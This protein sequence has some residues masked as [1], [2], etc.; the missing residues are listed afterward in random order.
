MSMKWS[1]PK[2][3]NIATLGDQF[4]SQQ[5]RDD[6]SV[7]LDNGSQT[8]NGKDSQSGKHANQYHPPYGY[9]YPPSQ[10][11]LQGGPQLYH[12]SPFNLTQHIL[13]PT[14]SVSRRFPSYWP[15]WQRYDLNQG[16]WDKSQRFPPQQ[17]PG[18]G[19]LSPGAL[20]ATRTSGKQ[21]SQSCNILKLNSSTWTS[22][23]RTWETFH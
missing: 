16:S 8:A 23:W 19:P 9:H 5:R 21:S 17:F 18:Q 10:Q 22:C 4:G 12:H 2:T 20:S 1:P 7:T 11:P 3:A 6:N 14:T 13:R 15:Q